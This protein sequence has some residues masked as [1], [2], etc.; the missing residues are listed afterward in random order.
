MQID[1]KA[2]KKILTM[3]LEVGVGTRNVYV[4]FFEEKF[5]AS[6]ES[7]FK[8]ESAEQLSSNSVPDYIHFA[9]K[10]MEEE[11]DRVNGCV[12]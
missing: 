6:S 7:F 10:R 12:L 9:H 11:L 3:L 2:V 8:Q 5:L 4:K 1:K